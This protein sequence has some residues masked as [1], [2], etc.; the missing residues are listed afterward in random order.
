MKLSIVHR[1]SVTSIG[2]LGLL[3]SSL[4]YA[5]PAEDTTSAS[6]RLRVTVDGAT[7][8][9]AIGQPGAASD[10]LTATVAAKVD[11]RWLHARDYPKHLVTE[12]VAND[13]LGMAHEWTVR[14]SG[15]D[16]VP[17]LLCILH[18][19]MDRPLGQN[20]VQG[21]NGSRTTINVEAIRPMEAT[22]GKI[23][24]LGGPVPS[25]RVLSD[26]FSE[27][28]P[29][30]KIHDLTDAEG[31]YRGV[32]SQLLYN[33]Q[34]HLSFFVGAL[35][36]NRFL[37]VS[38]LHVGGSLNAPQI[39]AFEVDSTGT[40]ELTKENSLKQSPPEDQM[41]LSLVLPPG[42]AL[43]S[44][45][46]FFGVSG[47]YHSQLEM[48]GSLIRVLHHARISSPSLMGWWSWTAYYFG[49]NDGSAL[50]NAHCLAH[51]FKSVGYRFFP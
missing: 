31:M 47:D 48:Y 42:G 4:N 32:G 26:S 39:Q 40:T 29:A 14:H 24:D 30:M 46:L 8:D 28:R 2:V 13:D 25:D 20:Q 11:G 23:M 5:M 34:S 41:E 7:G 51:L 19:Y 15:L 49:L 16:S 45:K 43:D 3:M 21:F 1:Q 33:R 22:Q 6:Q 9:Y 36:S 38:R 18:S 35:T 17:E 37:T 50:T 12:S 44:E 27:D 10:V